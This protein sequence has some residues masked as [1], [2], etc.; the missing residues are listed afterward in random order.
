MKAEAEAREQLA[1]TEKRLEHYQ[2]VYGNAQPT[3][4][5]DAQA[6]LEQLEQKEHECQVLRLQAKQHEQAESALYAELE[7]LSAAWEVLDRQVKSKVFDLGAME[8]RLTK[9]S[10]ER[11]KLENKFYAAMRDK[12]AIEI[13]RKNLTRNLE[14]QTK[15]L[16]TQSEAEKHLLVRVRALENEIGSAR[17]MYELQKSAVASVTK[18]LNEWKS[19][20][21]TESKRFQSVRDVFVEREKKL[22]KMRAELLDAKEAIVLKKLEAERYTAK[23]KVM[24]QNQSVAPSSREALLQAEV[25][26]CMSILK[27]STCNMNMRNTVI[28][29][30]MHSFCK[31]CVESRIST[32]QRKCPACNLPFSQGEVQTLFF[33]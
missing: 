14:K 7:N 33:Q 32:R 5:L 4:P 29:K 20:A 31:S 16:E 10:L 2:L 17:K 25:N 26:K 12:E 28:T 22:M 13:E 30:C 15:V 21:E 19:R 23:M 9:S 3:I 11:A 27:C 8:E 24:A 6:L 1:D 18:D